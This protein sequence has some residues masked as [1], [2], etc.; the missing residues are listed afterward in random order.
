MKYFLIIFLLLS[1]GSNAQNTSISPT[2]FIGATSAGGQIS[3]NAKLISIRNAVDSQPLS[4]FKIVSF[5][6]IAGDQVL[7]T[8]NT[9]NNGKGALLSKE[10]EN[11]IKACS[12]GDPI[13]IT[14]TVEGPDG[15]A[16]LIGA[17]Y[18][19]K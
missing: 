13:S 1:F 2:L 16:R 5:D 10:M 3:K 14:A 12:S 11:L 9:L 18:H 6:L 17:G 4:D 8:V 19:I 7:R 15:I